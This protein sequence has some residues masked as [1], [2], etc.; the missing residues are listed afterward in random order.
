VVVAVGA[1]V[2]GEQALG[3]EVRAPLPNG[4]LPRC[5]LEERAGDS[6]LRLASLCKRPKL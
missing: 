2:L 3:D 5:F 4:I 1:A 6:R